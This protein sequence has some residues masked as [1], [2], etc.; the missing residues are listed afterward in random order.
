MCVARCQLGLQY[1][2]VIFMTST[3][4]FAH[5]NLEVKMTEDAYVNDESFDNQRN[6]ESV[7]FLNL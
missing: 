1:H 2:P 5:T 6:N 7:R 4:N 3:C